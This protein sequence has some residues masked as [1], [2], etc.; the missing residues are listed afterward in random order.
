MVF[1]EK[2][3]TQVFSTVIGKDCHIK[4]DLIAQDSVRIEG[5]I[6]GNVQS[7]KAVCITENA[8]V[9]GNLKA[10]DIINSGLVK[11][12]VTATDSLEI[13][14]TG[15]VIGDVYTQSLKINLGAKINGR[16]SMDNQTET[17]TKEE[18]NL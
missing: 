6:E 12:N 5:Q 15:I 9:T 11:G 1:G 13:E 7:D 14:K 8:V 18:D 16:M 10:Q 17:K 2:T 4:G 3:K